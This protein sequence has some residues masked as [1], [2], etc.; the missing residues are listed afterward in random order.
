MRN[1]LDNRWVIFG[2]GLALVAVVVIVAVVLSLRS[3]PQYP[4]DNTY[5]DPASHETISDP[6]G[7]SPDVNGSAPDQPIFLGLSKLTER[8]VSQFQINDLKEAFYR[9]KKASNKPVKEVSI[10]VDTVQVIPFDPHTATEPVTTVKFDVLI[11]RKDR[12]NAKM[13]YD[14]TS[15]MRLVLSDPNSHNQVYDSGVIDLTVHND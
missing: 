1:L 9:Y 12:L 4:A 8:G 7:K 13:T 6:H 2:G 10:Y 5:V 11:D 15:A 14:T 3:Q